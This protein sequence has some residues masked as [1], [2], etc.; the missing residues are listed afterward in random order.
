MK[1]LAI[2]GSPH[3][4]GNTYIAL[5]QI[6]AFLKEKGHDVEILQVGIKD[7]KGCTA[8]SACLKS[9]KCIVNDEMND[10]VAKMIASDAIILGSPV[11]YAGVSGQMKCF[12]D[13]AFYL[14]TRNCELKGKVGAA[15][16]AVRRTGGSTALDCLMKFLNYGEMVIAN[17]C[18]WPV[19][20]GWKAGEVL[21]DEEGLDTLNL[22]AQNIDWL[23]SLKE[24]GKPYPDTKKR[25]MTSFI[26]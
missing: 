11:H 5:T 21:Q 12:L 23:L 16:V 10:Y 18:Y 13:R 4:N 26:R 20:H 2:N 19:I 3:E 22:L 25:R 24:T 6:T 17:G 7:F 8:C 15:V 14:A 9:G 1:V